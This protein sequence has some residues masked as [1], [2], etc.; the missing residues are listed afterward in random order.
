MTTKMEKKS[1]NAFK[2]FCLNGAATVTVE[3]GIDSY[4]ELGATAADACDPSVSVVVGGDTVDEATPGT[5]V[6][7]YDATDASG[8][9]AVQV[10]RTVEVVDTTAPVIT[11]N[12]D[13]TV[14]LECGIDSYT[15]LGATAADAC[16]SSVS[17]VIGGDAVDAA[18][19]GTYV[20]TYDATDASG[21]A[22]VQVTRTVEVVDT[23][24]PVITLSGDATIT[25][26]CDIDTY[27]ELGATAED[28]CD[29]SVSVVIGG[30][31]VDATT[32]GTYVVT[33]DA[34]DA[35]GNAAIQVTRTVEVGDSTP[36]VI[37]LNGD[38]IVFLECGVDTYD[39]LGA[40]VADA[41]DPSVQVVVGGDVVDTTPTPP[42]EVNGVLPPNSSASVRVFVVTYNATDAAGNTADEVTRTV[43]V[44]DTT[45]PVITLNGEDEV[46][47]EC[48]VDTYTELGAVVQDI[49]DANVELKIGGDPV[50]LTK[51]G[52][53]V[54][55]YNAT[56]ANGNVA[57]EVTRTV[58]VVDTTAP[59][60]RLTG[61]AAVM[62]ECGIDRYTELGAIAEDA[63]DSDIEV[64]VG[65]DTVDSVKP[66]IYTVTYNA[67][68]SA[69][70]VAAEVRRTV[71]VADTEPP[72]ITLNGEVM[73]TLECGVDTYEELGATADD[74]CDPEV[75]VTVG[76]D[77]VDP[78]TPGIYTVTYNATDSAGN[79][80][81]EVTRTV[82]VGDTEPP[83]ITLN[84]AA[85]VTLECGVDT[86]EELGATAE[87]ACDPEV[88][89]TVGGDTVDP[90]TPGIYTVT[91]NA[92][93]S[94]GNAADEVT[95][96]V[97][98]GD[99]EPPVITLNGEATVTIECSVDTYEE[100]GAT[101]E[102][103]C[104]SE[105]AVIVGGDT[106]DPA[107]PGTYTVTYN[108]TDSAGNAADEVTRT[109][110]V[111]DT[112][113]PVITLNGEGSI[114]LECGVDTY[115]ELG[116]TAEDAC[117][118]EVVV[119]VGGDTVDTNRP[120]IYTVTYNA[121]DASGNVA[122]EVTRTVEVVSTSLPE[123]GV[124]FD[125]VG[126][127]PIVFWDS[128]AGVTYQLQVSEN[129]R[130]DSWRELAVLVGDGTTLE[131]EDSIS[132]A[133]TGFY[134]LLI[135]PTSP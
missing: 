17:V 33:Y 7:T 35:S 2:S 90:A 39:E 77:T 107:A 114:T 94:A 74:A 50:D 63:C 73:V 59:V 110:V 135:L 128:K 70:N 124:R 1:S 98:V 51:L 31:A 16:D 20:V 71:I 116:A 10:T 78:A 68:D 85:M 133:G 105:V 23:T 55:T 127:K 82:V 120:G 58:T 40:V 45:A 57:D 25:L 81:D 96:T 24:A 11:L 91:Y 56:D 79:A 92:T 6:V 34:T 18:T 65:G 134:R 44:R 29:P 103:V 115:A 21:N 15:E 93:D 46:T 41:C 36:S 113:P 27:T 97:V 126:K 106:V 108:A 19:P 67:T 61:E 49:C 121:T 99:T 104:D 76:G 87:D 42:E 43:I 5:Y 117:D 89:V 4:T 72:V 8:N 118:P 100:L 26:E 111:E 3:C 132:A 47:L 48:G 88:T 38:A 83:V 122:D 112:R 84:G 125:W 123:L 95:R 54:V 75:T 66:G 13:V 14:T 80:A 28:I 37:T 64:A 119:N 32:P 52:T 9:A 109:V 53:Y 129:L 101:A 30:D 12:G 86:Y 69:G 60:I 22:A 130:P 62:I 131:V 102:D